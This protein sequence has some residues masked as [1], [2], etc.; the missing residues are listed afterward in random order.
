[1]MTTHGV[2]PNQPTEAYMQTSPGEPDLSQ[3]ELTRNTASLKTLKQNIN[4][5]CYKLFESFSPCN[6]IAVIADLIQ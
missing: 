2:D 5:C 6:I 1:M 4:T 3:T